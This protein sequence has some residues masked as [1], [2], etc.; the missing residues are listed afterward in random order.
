MPVARWA[1]STVAPAHRACCTRRNRP[2]RGTDACSSSSAGSRRGGRP[3]PENCDCGCSN[4][5]RA[6][7]GASVKLRPMAMASPTLFIVVVSVSSAFGNFSN[8]NRGTFD[9]D[10]VH[11]G[12]NEAGVSAVMSLGIS[13]GCSRRPS[14][15]DLGDPGKPGRLT[16][17]RAGA[18]HPRV[19]L[20]DD[21]APVGR[22]HRELDVAATG[23][24]ADGADDVDPDVAQPLVLP[25]G[26]RQRRATV[27]ESPVCTPMGS[28]FSIEQITTTLS[29]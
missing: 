2:S 25:V 20:D 4:D 16:R 18:R 26:Q 13:S 10:V 7:C 24:D 9:H 29:A 14:G 21:D 1:C 17:Q 11:A 12:S 6:F 8:A 5:R 22:V 27:M 15:R 19:H 23:V 28:R 3:L